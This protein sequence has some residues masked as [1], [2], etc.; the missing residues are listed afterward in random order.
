MK[1]E[2][3]NKNLVINGESHNI[4]VQTVHD[5]VTHFDLKP[6]LII[7]EVNGDIINRDSWDKTIVEE[8]SKIELVEFIAGG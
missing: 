6:N 2:K 1:N 7:A 4:N 5:V 3:S 8:G